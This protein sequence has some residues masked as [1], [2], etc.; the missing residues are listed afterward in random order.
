MHKAIPLVHCSVTVHT[1]F[2]LSFR[3]CVTDSWHN[4]CVVS[5]TCHHAVFRVV[6]VHTVAVKLDREV[7]LLYCKRIAAKVDKSAY[8]TSI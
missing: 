4:L 1:S 3:C 8:K 5:L 2:S 6:V 7:V